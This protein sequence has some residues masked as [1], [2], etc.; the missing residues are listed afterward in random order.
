MMK[1]KGD[2]FDE[3]LD[4]L[5]KIVLAIANNAHKIE[6]PQVREAVQKEVSRLLLELERKLKSL[7]QSGE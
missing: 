7:S 1:E 3:K 5:E 4:E 6:P 2:K